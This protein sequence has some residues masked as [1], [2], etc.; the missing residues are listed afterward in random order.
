[1]SSDRR[2]VLACWLEFVFQGQGKQGGRNDASDWRELVE[3]EGAFCSEDYAALNE[4]GE[5]TVNFH[6]LL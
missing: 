2:C 5:C 1:M 6:L 3:T 4:S